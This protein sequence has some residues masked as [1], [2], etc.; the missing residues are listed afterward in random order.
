VVQPGDAEGD[1][2]SKRIEKAGEA[3]KQSYREGMITTIELSP[4]GQLQL[5]KEFCEKNKLKAGTSL[6]VVS[7]GKAL[8]VTAQEEPNVEEF[9]RLVAE[10]GAPDREA[11]AE[12]EKMIQETIAEFRQSKQQRR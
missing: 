1:V 9:E 11:T 4:S 7:L 3:G 8:Y 5:P 12:E 2:G 6:R 10:S